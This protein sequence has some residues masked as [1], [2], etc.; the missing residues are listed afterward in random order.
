ML[1][2]REIHQK[3]HSYM[4]YDIVRWIKMIYSSKSLSEFFVEY[5]L[6]QWL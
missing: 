1:P 2:P 4:I 5:P 6:Q 3:D